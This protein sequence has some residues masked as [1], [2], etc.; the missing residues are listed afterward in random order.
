[1]KV[2]IE[3]IA[4]V[5]FFTIYA[6]GYLFCNKYYPKGSEGKTSEDDIEMKN[7]RKYNRVEERYYKDSIY[8]TSEIIDTVVALHGCDFGNLRNYKKRMQKAAIE[9]YR[10]LDSGYNSH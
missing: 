1:M 2:K 8:V 9:V 3:A 6:S 7:P 10:P 4:A 5:V